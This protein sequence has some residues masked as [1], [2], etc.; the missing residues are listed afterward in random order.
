M[1]T[2]KPPVARMD[3]YVR[4][5]GYGVT[6]IHDFIAAISESERSKTSY[7]K[8]MTDYITAFVNTVTPALSQLSYAER[9]KDL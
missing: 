1:I 5:Q 2:R 6:T 3:G 7:S 9:E 8:L 4:F